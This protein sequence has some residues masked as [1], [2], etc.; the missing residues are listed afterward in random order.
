MVS[1]IYIDKLLQ[2]PSQ[3]C[4]DTF[5]NV[6]SYLNSVLSSRESVIAEAKRHIQ[7]LLKIIIM[8]SQNRK[9]Y[10]VNTKA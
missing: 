9:Y 10:E 7:Y 4:Q 5:D 6:L 2:A 8:I 1:D 3:A